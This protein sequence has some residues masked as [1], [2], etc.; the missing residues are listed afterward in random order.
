MKKWVMISFPFILGTIVSLILIFIKICDIQIIKVDFVLNA[1]ITCVVTL[2]GFILASLS[3]IISMSNS[4]IMLKI[5]AEGGLTELS[6]RYSI[7]LL[8]SLLM[9]CVFIALGASMNTENIV[10]ARWIIVCSGLTVAYLL[11][12]F[13]TVY[14]LIRIIHKIPLTTDLQINNKPSVPDGEFR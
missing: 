13:T 2:A 6:I 4:A 5:K 11:S 10:R 7:T 12:L 9:L 14:Y 8:L 1:I 3:I